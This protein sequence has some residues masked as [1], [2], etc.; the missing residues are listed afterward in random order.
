[1]HLFFSVAQKE[2]MRIECDT[3]SEAK[4]VKESVDKAYW[5]GKQRKRKNDE[6]KEK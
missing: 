2:M 6:E 1:M 3:E 4:L 5:E